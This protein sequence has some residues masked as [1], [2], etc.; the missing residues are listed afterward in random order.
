[1]TKSLFK[2]FKSF[3]AGIGIII[4]SVS[5]IPPMNRTTCFKGSEVPL[6]LGDTTSL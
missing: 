2:S 3:L 6:Q 4:K 5:K 1:M